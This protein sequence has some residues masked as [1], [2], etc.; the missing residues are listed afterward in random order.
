MISFLETRPM[1]LAASPQFLKHNMDIVKRELAELE[2]RAD[3]THR[4]R[5]L[6]KTTEQGHIVALAEEME[7]IGEEFVTVENKSH[8]TSF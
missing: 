3:K 5:H 6:R 8:A 1:K 7:R 4:H 2:K